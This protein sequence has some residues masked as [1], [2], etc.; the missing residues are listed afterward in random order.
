MLTR[1]AKHSRRQG[2]NPLRLSAI[3][4]LALCG[5]SVAACHKAPAK[6][7]ESV[8]IESIDHAGNRIEFP[9]PQPLKVPGLA[10]VPAHQV[11]S[12]LNVRSKLGYG[13]FVWD[14]AGVPS[15]PVWVLVDLGAQ[16]MSV[17]RAGHEIG[18]TVFLFG[19]TGKP[20]PVGDLR[21]KQKS[22][23][24]WSH[25]YDAAMPYALRL[26]DD[27]VAI[28]G[29]EVLPG[30]A[31]HGCLGVPVDFARRLFSVVNVGDEVMVVRSSRD[32]TA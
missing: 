21:V 31:T 29:S 16:T 17:F 24:Y 27:G 2:P 32:H 7:A 11:R 30:S 12:L 4:L 10:N 28:H 26:T 25:T 3:G 1:A 23:D 9:Q 19:M 6:P 5:L 22:K 20:T 18:T 14:T 8:S 13:D 15:G